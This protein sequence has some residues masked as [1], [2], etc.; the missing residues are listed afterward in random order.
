[1]GGWSTSLRLETL[2]SRLFSLTIPGGDMTTY[3][4]ELDGLQTLFAPL[5]ELREMVVNWWI[6]SPER[7]KTKDIRTR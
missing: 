3:R 2:S 1:M 6:S 7:K 4:W 5:T